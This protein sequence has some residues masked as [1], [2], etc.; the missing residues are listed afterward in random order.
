MLNKKAQSVAEY[1][2]FISMMIAAIAMMQLYLKR[3]IQARYADGADEI[4]GCLTRLDWTDISITPVTPM[5]SKQYEPSEIESRKTQRVVEDK[6]IYKMEK[7]G[8]VTRDII[9]RT[10]NEKGDYIKYDY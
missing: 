10:E 6:L 4:I 5:A 3:G 7:G 9:T 8:K 2:V 1:A